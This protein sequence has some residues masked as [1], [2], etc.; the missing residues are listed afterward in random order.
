MTVVG[1]PDLTTFA[2]REYFSGLG[3]ALPI[4]SFDRLVLG[5]SRVSRAPSDVIYFTFFINSYFFVIVE[6]F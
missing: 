6:E 4:P 1:L 2:V 5:E 3:Y